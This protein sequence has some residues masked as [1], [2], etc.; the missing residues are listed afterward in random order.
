MGYT[1]GEWRVTK[2]RPLDNWVIDVNGDDLINRVTVAQLYDNLDDA[3]LIAQ[4]PAM[5]EALKAF[6]HYLCAPHPH[7][8]KLK[9]YATKLMEQAIAKVED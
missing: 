5:Y 1:K 6:D 3:K 8:L 7:N 2:H 9:A 4:A